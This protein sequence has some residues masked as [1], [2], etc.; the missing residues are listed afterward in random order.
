M[1]VGG[2][3]KP[4]MALNENLGLMRDYTVISRNFVEEQ[5]GMRPEAIFFRGHSAG[6]GHC[7]KD[8]RPGD[9]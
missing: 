3:G 6:G 4:G 5:L 9:A 7:R 2:A 1:V 8:S